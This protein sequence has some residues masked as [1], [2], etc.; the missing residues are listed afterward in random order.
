MVFLRRH[1]AQ[2]ALPHHAEQTGLSPAAAG[3][4]RL[5]EPGQGS[6]GRARVDVGAK[7]G[8][9]VRVRAP[10]QTSRAECASPRPHSPPAPSPD[11][12]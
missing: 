8:V 3:G 10:Q 12:C 2:H 6:S 5:G 9:K 4:R 7:V 1:Q 11:A